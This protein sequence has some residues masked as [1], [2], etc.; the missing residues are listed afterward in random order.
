[1]MKKLLI[2]LF[3]VPNLVFGATSDFQVSYIPYDDVTP[4]TT[5]TLVSVIP[6]AFS[7]I[8]LVW[9]A[10]TDDM[11]LSGYVVLRDGNPVATTSQLTFSDVSLSAST[12]YT[13]EVYAF[14]S[15]FNVS[16]TSNS[17]STT[18]LEAPPP[19]ENE[20]EDRSSKRTSSSGSG[21]VLPLEL[22][23][24]K[25]T[26]GETEV[27][28][29]WTTN[30]IARFSLRWGETR[31]LS[32]GY[33]ENDVLKDKQKTT[34]Y[35]LK[36]DTEYFFELVGIDNK[37][38]TT[39]LRQDSIKTEAEVK[40]GYVQNVSRF[41]AMVVDELGVLLSWRL[42]EIQDLQKVR[43]VKNH[44]SWP[45]SIND[46]EV[47]YEG[48]KS[49][50]LDKDGL[51]NRDTQ[52]YTIFVINDEGEWSSG[53]IVTARRYSS[54]ITDYGSDG[55]LS[56]DKPQATTTEEERGGE[57]KVEEGDDWG[58][59]KLGFRD[60]EII[61][62][63]REYS[64]VDERITLSYK[65]SFLIRIKREAL[66]PHLKI[67]IATLVDP[68]NHSYSY[69]F[70]VK[71]NE[72]KTAYETVLAPLQTLGI[73]SLQVE[74]IDL[75]NKTIGHY[76][77]QIDFIIGND[78]VDSSEENSVFTGGMFCQIFLPIILIFLIIS[79]FF[80]FIILA[81]RRR[82]EEEERKKL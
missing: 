66:P 58:K 39:V 74:V 51:K 32:D 64:F 71:L 17:L 37:G 1:M 33:V 63:S 53:A 38:R 48:L 6:V 2:W 73:S 10:S 44:Y 52:Y 5:P 15:A 27:S 50:F 24:F 46:G 69:S 21:G 31:D 11:M 57:V 3:L 67:I 22:I 28:F 54:I 72:D 43:L 4:P 23:A 20:E 14:D 18:T 45:T 25:T 41:T 30:R 12:T 55:S 80:F 29:D 47:I 35:N 59:L 36:P 9:S 19:P 7:Q 26:S 62:N 81:K 8:D 40:K 16:T 79:L 77:K 75:E 68:T 65:D 34:I 42:P 61:Q 70:I 78:E 49:S 56:D 60:I 76:K 13:Y 82:E